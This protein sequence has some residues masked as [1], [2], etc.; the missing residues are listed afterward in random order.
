MKLVYFAKQIWL[1]LMA[2]SSADY[3][4]RR[5]RA[6]LNSGSGSYDELAHYKA[7][8]LNE[9]VRENGVQSVIEL[10]CGDG[11]QLTLAQYPR[12]LGLDV[13][14]SAVDL[15]A[16]RFGDDATKSFLW[17]DPRRTLRL[18]SFVAADL[19]LSLD[20]I[21]HLLEDDVYEAYLRDVFSLSRRFVIIYSS[22]HDERPHVRH[23]RHH[24][25]TD[26]VARHFPQFALRKHLPN[27]HSTRT[28]ADFYIF[29]K[30]SG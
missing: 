23:V 15:C 18:S 3:W 14:S 5:Y 28:F 19:T 10:G 17:Y 27:P 16:K 1:G 8:L 30:T 24:K 7:Q 26:D 29:E 20:V 25:F 6:G 12:Y 4:E 11:N 22:N 9:F 21:Y 13:S 2:R